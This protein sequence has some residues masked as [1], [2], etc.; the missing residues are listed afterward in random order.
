MD[1]SKLLTSQIGKMIMGSLEKEGKANPM[2]I[3]QIASSA[4]PT[5]KKFIG[6]SAASNLVNQDNPIEKLLKFKNPDDS[7]SFGDLQNFGK[8]FMNSVTGD[9]ETSSVEEEIAQ[10]SG[11][12]AS[13]VSSVL[14]LIATALGAAKQ[15]EAIP[16]NE[17]QGEEG[18]LSGLMS[19]LDRDG[20][21]SALDDVM[22]MAGKL[23]S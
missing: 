13:K 17:Q 3:M 23:F 21:G 10:S 1:I 7:F 20:D 2:E 5:L 19:L 16:G 15:A 14:P 8:S 9:T 11:L 4:L 6:S 22:S 18:G 12:D